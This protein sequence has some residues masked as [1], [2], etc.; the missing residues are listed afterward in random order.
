MQQ[1]LKA[2]TIE[3]PEPKR[4]EDVTKTRERNFYRYHR[5][6]GHS[7]EN[8]YTLKC[9]IQRMI[10]RGEIITSEGRGKNTM[11]TVN[12]SSAK[13]EEQEIKGKENQKVLKNAA[14]ITLRLGKRVTSP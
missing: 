4:P 9:I 2:G 1:L 14:M 13:Q 12:M 10:N 6:V 7:T 8:C 5:L 3:L 11:A